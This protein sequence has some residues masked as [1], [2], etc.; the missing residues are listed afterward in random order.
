LWGR[1]RSNEFT[2]NFAR[3]SPRVWQFEFMRKKFRILLAILLVPFIIGLAWFIWPA[4]EPSFQGRLLSDWMI[5]FATSDDNSPTQRQKDAEVAI[6]KIGTNG[7]PIYLQWLAKKEFAPKEKAILLLRKQSVFS[8]R[9]FTADEYHIM[10]RYGFEILGSEAAYAVPDLVG[11]LTG[12]NDKDIQAEA[13]V[14]LGRIGSAASNAVPALIKSLDGTNGFVRYMAASALAAI[15][16][17]PDLAVPA[18]LKACEK[19]QNNWTLAH[20][21]I[22]SLGEFGPEARS[23][24]PE[25]TNLLMLHPQDERMRVAI[26]DALKQIDPHAASEV[27]IKH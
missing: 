9:I 2:R 3:F 14:S 23:A 15:H 22:Q 11:L 25:L 7:V 21:T 5:Q 12:T 4:H 19:Y 10:G 17:K 8:F 1:S 27:G 13:A 18:L 20:C 24:I 16:E 6:R 26:M